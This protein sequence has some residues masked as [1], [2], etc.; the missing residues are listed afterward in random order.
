VGNQI[1]KVK[2]ESKELQRTHSNFNKDENI[3]VKIP[4]SLKEASDLKNIM[5]HSHN[6]QILKTVKGKLKLDVLLKTC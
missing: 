6:G 4:K 5:F 3:S 1:K 2:S